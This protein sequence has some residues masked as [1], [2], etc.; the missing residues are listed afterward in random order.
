LI[1]VHH[2]HQSRS[3]RIVWLLEELGLPYELKT[4]RRNPKTMLAPPELK[5]IHPL[6]KSP[7]LVDDGIVMIESGAIIQLLLERHGADS[8]LRPPLDTP[9]HR[10]YLTFL[11]F[12]EGSMMPPLLLRLIFNRMGAMAPALVRPLVRAITRP[13]DAGFVDPN[14]KATLAYLEAELAKRAWF[15]GTA[16]S[17]ADIQM[18]FPI[19]M[20]RSRGGLDAS[21]PNLME[22]LARIH[23]RPAYQR[24]LAQ[25]GESAA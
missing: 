14:I 2:L 17:A 6:G 15:A 24:A 4:Y 13:V 10:D 5:A 19:A 8:G 23:A 16:F 11:H 3:L 18:S 12:A 25:V 9:E 21:H 22:F 1:T 20:A 7:I